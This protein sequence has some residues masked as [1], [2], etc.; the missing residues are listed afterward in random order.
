MSSGTVK[1]NNASSVAVWLAI[2]LPTNGEPWGGGS[3]VSANSSLT[4]APAASVA[5][6]AIK[7]WPAAEAGGVPVNVPAPGSKTSQAGRGS[8]FASAAVNVSTG[9]STSAKLLAGT[10]K[11]IAL[12]ASPDWSA[13]GLAT[14]GASF[15]G[16]T[17]ME[18]LSLAL[19]PVGSV[20]VTVTAIDPICG[21]SGVPVKVPVPA[22][23]AS[24]A[25]RG[26][27]FVS[28]ADRT[29]ASSSVNMPAGSV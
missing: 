5:V 4:L 16:A 19:R 15:T 7:I 8:P 27:P 21:S 3:I 25:G 26:S 11:L 13:S 28:V 17:V 6:T 24:Q 22:S 23:K 2:G 18:K 1:S 12:S 10:W 29:S 20:A 9:S 14:V